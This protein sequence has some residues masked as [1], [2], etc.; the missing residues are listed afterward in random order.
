MNPIVVSLPGNEGLSAALV[1]VMA[2]KPGELSMRQFPDGETYLR[3]LEPAAERDVVIA[4]TL[5]R[6]NDKLVNLYLLASSLRAAGARRIVLVA[7]YLPYM[8]QD[9]IF[10]DGEGVSAAHIGRWL[11]SFL[12]GVVTV[13]PHLH[14]IRAL[15]EVYSVPTRQ[16]SS[17]TAIGR[18]VRE[19]VTHPLLIGPD[20]ES[21]TWVTD[22]AKDVGCHYLILKKLRH[23]DRD[24]SI[25]VPGVQAFMEYTP[26]LLDDIVAS[27]ATM[28]EAAHRL[29]A[30]GTAPP[31]CIGVHALF[32]KDASDQLRQ[33][34]AQRIITCN[35]VV[36]PSNV[37][38]LNR[39]IALATAGLLAD[40]P[41]KGATAA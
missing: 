10:K 35:T 33:A 11:S 32:A 19:N 38:D 23:S 34:G 7:P 25:V 13:D 28:I 31:V 26:V 1:E 6:P 37:I 4:C 22:T 40:L 21:G 15:S 29:R 30:L 20:E 12:D 18:W 14:R 39:E 27:G 36:H 24:V 5:D 2:A 9:H 17:A 41:A 8:R 16:V 3:V